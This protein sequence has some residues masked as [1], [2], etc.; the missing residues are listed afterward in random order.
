MAAA[1]WIACAVSTAGLPISALLA[2]LHG[3]RRAP[4]GPAAPAA[5]VEE[6]DAIA[7]Q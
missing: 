3:K 2:R 7:G 6:V 1:A 4:A 5:P